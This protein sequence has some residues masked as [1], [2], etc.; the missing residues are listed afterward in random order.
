MQS[1]L[2][3]TLS[4]F[5]MTFQNTHRFSLISIP[6]GFWSHSSSYR[7][8]ET[9]YLKQDL[10]INSHLAWA[11][12]GEVVLFVPPTHDLVILHGY[13]VL[14]CRAEKFP[15]NVCI[16][17]CTLY[18]YLDH[19]LFQGNKI[20]LVQFWTGRSGAG[21]APSNEIMQMRMS[22]C[23]ITG[24]SRVGSPPPPPSPDRPPQTDHSSLA[25]Q[26]P[27][28][29]NH[30]SI[31]SSPCLWQLPQPAATCHVRTLYSCTDHFSRR[32]TLGWTDTSV[33]HTASSW[34]FY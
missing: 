1:L 19:V 4:S 5:F 8:L 3:A 17:V 2:V 30:C 24:L 34:R 20:S 26:D 21:N 9:Y 14:M 31:Y 12:W 6:V 29:S 23:H 33:T 32:N 18:M 16:G 13:V 22:I 10:W 27:H 15:V 28:P 25:K 7:D 11:G